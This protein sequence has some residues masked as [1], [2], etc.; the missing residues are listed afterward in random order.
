MVGAHANTVQSSMIQT[1]KNIYAKEGITGLYRGAVP[2]LLRVFPSAGIY[3]G[4]FT[5]FE[6]YMKKLR[7]KDTLHSVDR[8]FVGATAR[9]VAVVAVSPFTV[10]KTRF[11]YA[12]K[13]LMVT[14]F[15]LL[16]T[17]RVSIIMLF[18]R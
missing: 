14:V 4:L 8:F 13:E 12:K 9:T 3:F 15:Y 7:N 17:V 2:T 10:I 16:T 5:P 6:Q 18:P 1:A 11:E